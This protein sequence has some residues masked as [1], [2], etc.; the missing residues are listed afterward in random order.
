MKKLII[1]GGNKLGLTT[2]LVNP[3]GTKERFITKINRFFEKRI[4][5]KLRDNDLFAK[6]KYYE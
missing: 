1:K 5:R 2:I 6:G 3:V 4:L